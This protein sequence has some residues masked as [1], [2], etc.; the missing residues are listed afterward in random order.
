MH[1]VNRL[2]QFISVAALSTVALAMKPNMFIFI[3]RE[4]RPHVWRAE[5]YSTKALY[6]LCRCQNFTDNTRVGQKLCSVFHIT[7]QSIRTVLIDNKMPLNHS[8]LLLSIENALP[9]IFA[10]IFM[11]LL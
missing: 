5:L 7:V 2:L 3:A 10:S 6:G 4:V 8:Y 1:S 11:Y 9:G